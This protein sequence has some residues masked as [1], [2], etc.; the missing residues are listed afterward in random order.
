MT[1]GLELAAAAVAIVWRAP[2]THQALALS[3]DDVWFWT[4]ASP[5]PR[6]ADVTG[7]FR[8]EATPAE[9]AALTA[10]SPGDD[11]PG[12]LALQLT[13][14]G[15]T[16]RV[17]V[18]SVLGRQVGAAVDPL[19]DRLRATPVSAVALTAAIVTPPGGL[20]AMLGLTVDSIGTKPAV[21]GL[22]AGAVR[23]GVPDGAWQPVPPPR[24]GL[25]D[26]AGTLLDGLYGAAT[27]P[28]GA[29]GAWVLPGVPADEAQ[30]VRIG[31][32][33]R[34]AGPVPAGMVAFEVTA[35]LT[36]S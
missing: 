11:E 35:P 18:G 23:L 36:S 9:R 24:M 19:L 2:G 30:R 17:A 21:L 7:T 1:V 25:V 5:E 13:V 20:P 15:R 22:D 31:G 29:R 10:L 28:A 16:A 27:V 14:A 33:I 8:T 4:F 12:G 26:G 3:G 32:T 6:W 34:V